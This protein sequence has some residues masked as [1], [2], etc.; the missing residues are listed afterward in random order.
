M[1]L[2][3][4]TPTGN[5]GRA[6]VG[7]LLQAGHRPTV[8]VRNPDRLA[9]EVRSAVDVVVG[10]QSD[11]AVLD[12]ALGGADALFWLSPPD[13]S[14]PSPIENYARYGKA[15]AD[16]VTRNGVTR[17]VH[18]SSYGAESSPGFGLIDGLA[19]NEAAF[20]A[21]GVAV[22]HLRPGFFYE[23]LFFQLNPLRNGQYFGSIRPDQPMAY[24]AVADIAQIAA[25][26][27]QDSNWTGQDAL[28]VRSGDVLTPTRF[29]AAAA[30]GTGRP[31]QYIEVPSEAVVESFLR[32]GASPRVAELYAEMEAR[33]NAYQ[34]PQEKTF[35]G[36]T[37]I[38]AWSA[39]A[40]RPA[41]G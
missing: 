17:V 33:F 18:L 3:I 34:V 6:L 15:A 32:I 22:R 21:T 8:I 1:K 30:A 25:E 13:Y 28:Y 36:S 14:S 12:Q 35:V 27:L 40:L 4:T 20:N 16:A 37:T 39:V 11:P 19:L 38:E 23:N 10:D 7:N 24:V 26:V 9:P 29:I 5:I 2:T 31:I 41:L